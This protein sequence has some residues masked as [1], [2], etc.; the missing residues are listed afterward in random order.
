MF[1]KKSLSTVLF[2]STRLI[3]IG[4]GVF[5]LLIIVSLISNNFVITELNELQIHI[6]FTNSMIKGDYNPIAFIGVFCFLILYSTFFLVLS[7]IFKTFSAEK[8]FTEVAIKYL[9]WFTI[10]NLILPVAYAVIGI[11]INNKI[12]FDDITPGLLHMGLGVF[13]AFI[14]TIFK[15]GFTLQEE[16]ELTI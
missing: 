14:A 5:L 12:V 10:L 13:A 11:L 3:M 4:Y 9:R 2:Y 16:N 8:L 15:L 6:P 1:G 7:L